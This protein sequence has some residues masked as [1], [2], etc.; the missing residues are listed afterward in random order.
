MRHLVVHVLLLLIFEPLHS[1]HEIDPN[2]LLH[3]KP[4][5][6]Y[7][8][9]KRRLRKRLAMSWTERFSITSYWNSNFRLSPQ[10]FS[11]SCW[12]SSACL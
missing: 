10:F 3:T 4:G 6:H 12:L 2:C 11:F 9:C 8:K 5:G 7:I 1:H